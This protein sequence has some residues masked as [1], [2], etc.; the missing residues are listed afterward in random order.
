MKKAFLL[1]LVIVVLSSLPGCNGGKT[2]SDV[3]GTE[4]ELRHATLLSMKELSD[5]TTLVTVKN[6]WDTTAVLDRYALVD[7]NARRPASIPAGFKII[8]VPVERSIVYSGLHASL[9]NELGK[10]NAVNGMCDIQY[11]N[12]SATSVAI[13]KGK[14]L[15]C[16]KNISPVIE[17][18]ISLKPEIILLS[19]YENSDD[20]SRY[21]SINVRLVE[22]ADYMEP[23]PLGRAEWMRFYGR[24][25]G[26]SA[27]ADSL[28]SQIENEYLSLSAEARKSKKHPSLI[29][30][31]V[32]SGIWYVTTS[33][34]VTGRLIED[35]GGINPFAG[36][37]NGGSAPL[38]AEEVLNTGK[39]A[40]FWLIRHSEPSLSLK[41]LA[42]DAPVY[43]KFK[44]F[45]NGNVYMANT[46]TTRLFE[47]G[48]F[49]PERT[50]RE[51]V[52]IL[53]PEIESTPL[54]YYIK[55]E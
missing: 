31:R 28:F 39:N 10:L 53:H 50:L 45:K 15:D 25:F 3:G 22:A 16:G 48:A 13:Q 7:R 34:S 19:P 29:F 4:V 37:K 12:D 38:S 43:S 17:R 21:K 11:V 52:R 2:S 30:D 47:D 23:T 55:A 32:Y 5:G 6:P 49:H 36:Y 1:V 8:S 24:L 18:I 14:I 27:K 26:A 51:M 44:A 54:K 20:E 33:G 9:L 40:D 46:V 41:G 35:A 42:G